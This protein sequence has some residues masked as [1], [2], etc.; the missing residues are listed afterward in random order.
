[1]QL[2]FRLVGN[3]PKCQKWQKRQILYLIA[4]QFV[5]LCLNRT[6]QI[7]ICEILSGTITFFFAFKSW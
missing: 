7:F 2:D 4:F 1:M 3:E 6:D 5:D